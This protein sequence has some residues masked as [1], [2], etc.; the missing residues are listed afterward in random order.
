MME[1]SNI[2]TLQILGIM[3]VILKLLNV[4]TWKWYLVI[5]C[6]GCEKLPSANYDSYALTM[7][8]ACNDRNQALVKRR[9]GELHSKQAD[10]TV[11]D[12][13]NDWNN[14][15]KMAYLCTILSAL[16]SFVF[17]FIYF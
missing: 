11:D 12:L 4:I 3:F 8:A 15:Y 2:S 5:V 7:D 17:F 10:T 14:V 6:S 13:W 9:A 16:S 1:N